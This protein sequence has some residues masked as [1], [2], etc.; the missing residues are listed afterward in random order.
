M[1]KAKELR[2][3]SVEDLEA[4][5]NDTRKELFYLRNK[6]QHDKKLDQPHLLRMKRREIARLLTILHEKQSASVRSAT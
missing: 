2:D 6:M 4:S 5:Y 1:I 3:K